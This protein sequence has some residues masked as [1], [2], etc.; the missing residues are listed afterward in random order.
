MNGPLLKRR[1]WSPYEDTHFWSIPIIYCP[2]LFCQGF[3]YVSKKN[4]C[5]R[6]FNIILV[7]KMRANL[8]NTTYFLKC[9]KMSVKFLVFINISFSRFRNDGLFRCVI[10]SSYYKNNFRQKISDSTS[11]IEPYKNGL[12]TS[13]L[14]FPNVE[15]NFI[16]NP[17]V[18]LPLW[19]Q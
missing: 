3:P 14:F 18:R 15:L 16:I 6:L 10:S 9:S 5:L 13:L 4:S 11:K 17:L 12:I 1:S 7:K 2:F 19:Q 8:N